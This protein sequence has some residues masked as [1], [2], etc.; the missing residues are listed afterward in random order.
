VSETRLEW[1][2]G[3]LVRALEAYAASTGD[4]TRAAIRRSI[5]DLQRRIRVEKRSKK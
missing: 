2:E 1:L 4:V 5:F 3:Y